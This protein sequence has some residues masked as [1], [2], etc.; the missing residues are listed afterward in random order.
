MQHASSLDLEAQPEMG[1]FPKLASFLG[2]PERKS[3]AFRGPYSGHL[4][5]LPIKN[6]NYRSRSQK[7]GNNFTQTPG[8]H[9]KLSNFLGSKSRD[10]PKGFGRVLRA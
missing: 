8:R 3:L 1:G 6:P 9:L 4:G 2:V 10:L 7:Y 5:K